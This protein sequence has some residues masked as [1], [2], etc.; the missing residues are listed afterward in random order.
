MPQFLLSDA[1]ADQLRDRTCALAAAFIIATRHPDVLQF[2]ARTV[3]GDV[4][5]ELRPNGAVRRVC[6]GNGHRK[7]RNNGDDPHLS[8]RRE[9]RDR[10]DE[11][12]LAVMRS[13]PDGSIGDWVTMIHKSRTSCVSALHR[14]RDA[15]LAESVEGKWKLVG[16]EAPREPAAK[17]I[18]PLSATAGREHRAHA[19]A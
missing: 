1:V 15:G 7:L 5:T 8:R 4:P 6:K 9:A 14:L 12:L 11:A 13:N 18:A 3:C 17:W 16:L 10:D 19:S 2:V